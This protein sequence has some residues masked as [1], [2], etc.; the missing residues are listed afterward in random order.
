MVGIETPWRGEVRRVHGQQNQL[1]NG[2]LYHG[3]NDEVKDI[4]KILEMDNLGNLA[5]LT[6]NYLIKG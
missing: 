6:G 4:I 2:R 3:K 5:R 1:N